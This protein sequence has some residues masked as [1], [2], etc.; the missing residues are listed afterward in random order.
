MAASPEEV[1]ANDLYIDELYVDSNYIDTSSTSDD[2]YANRIGSNP[3]P[4]ELVNKTKGY[5]WIAQIT[6]PKNASIDL[7]DYRFNICT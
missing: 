3:G 2:T 4:H 7:S 1:Y 5:K 6:N